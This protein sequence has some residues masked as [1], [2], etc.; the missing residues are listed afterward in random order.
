MPMTIGTMPLSPR[1]S[2]FSCAQ[3]SCHGDSCG[4]RLSTSFISGEEDTMK[5]FLAVY[6]AGAM[7]DAPRVEAPVVIQSTA[8]AVS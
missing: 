4:T 8:L 1:R 5:A 3:T 6:E 7:V 2:P